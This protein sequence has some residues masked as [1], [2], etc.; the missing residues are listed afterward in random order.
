[1]KQFSDLKNKRE[2]R[3]YKYLR[4][5]RSTVRD[6]QTSVDP[7]LL[8]RGMGR[9]VHHGITNNVMN[10]L[11][12]D[13]R[14]LVLS[15]LVE[16]ASIRSIER[17]TGINRNTIMSLLVASGEKARMVL[18]EQMRHIESKRIQVDE[19]WC[20]CGKKARN[21]TP[22]EKEIGRT[23]DQWVFVAID[24]DTKLVPIY[25]V[26]KRTDA[27]TQEFIRGL[28]E[29]VTSEHLQVT[30]DGL[31][32][33]VNAMYYGF[34]DRADYA[35]IIKNY[36]QELKEERRYSPAKLIGITIKP[37]IGEP[38]REHISTSYIERQNL[39]MRMS[40]RRFTRLTNGF[41]KK[42]ENLQAA[43]A[44]HF[45]HYNFLRVHRSLGCTPAVAAGI[46]PGT[47][48]WDAILR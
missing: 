46:T 30:S 21:C 29:R 12:I 14:K 15:Q 26:G 37:I 32:Q 22:E 18:D 39:T 6:E 35:Q 1:M 7:A 9:S 4:P 10:K 11:S 28:S 45:Y 40:M 23:G 41:S 33:Y 31:I 16:G 3:Y 36:G 38:D 27:D 5:L 43:V 34:G 25:L 17:I 47:W 2:C 20:Y 13:K 48:G 44:L 24:A 8:T 19:I 42:L